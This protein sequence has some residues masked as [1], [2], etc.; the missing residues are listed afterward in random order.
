VDSH[1][2]HCNIDTDVII[3][4]E[5]ENGNKQKPEEL[6]NI[7]ENFCMGRRRLEIFGS[8]DSMRPG[9]LTVGNG[10]T[11][12]TYDA[13][14]YLSYFQDGNLVGHHQGTFPTREWSLIARNRNVTA[15]VS[16]SEGPDG[17][18]IAFRH[19]GL[20]G[21]RVVSSASIIR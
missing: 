6:F 14:E 1:F 9:W 20:W 7:V 11:T 13:K 12:S 2:I 21:S 3:A 8:D 16:S 5:Y 19:A 18:S 4:E 10:M 15:K 17:W